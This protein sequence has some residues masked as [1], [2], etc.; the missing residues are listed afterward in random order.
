VIVGLGIDVCPVARIA[1]ILERHGALFADR[2]FTPHE[3]ER[4]GNGVVRSERLA[5]RWAAKE[6]AIKALGAPEGL[7]WHDMEVV[8]AAGG[9]PSLRLD[10]AAK[11]CAEA[12]GV[13]RALLSLSHAAGV[14][15]AVVV[16]ESVVNGN[17]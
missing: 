7:R 6:A 10:G 5:A 9:A 2:V 11:A 4:S 12:L 14:A 13:T 1:E 15:V 17:G 8:N 3:L 16:L